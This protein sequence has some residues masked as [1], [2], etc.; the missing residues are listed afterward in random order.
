MLLPKRIAAAALLVALLAAHAAP[1]SAASVSGTWSVNASGVWS[2]AGNWT[3]ASA[4][5]GAGATAGLTYDI[6]LADRTVTIDTASR[7]VGIL[8]IGDTGSAYRSYTLAAS[9]GASLILDNSAAAAQINKVLSDQYATEASDTISAPILL[10]GSLNISNA[11]HAATA[12]LTISGGIT[13]NSAG[14]KTI[15]NR[16]TS[17]SGVTLSGVIGD[18][19]GTVAVTQNSATSALTLSGANTYSGATTVSA[20]TLK[21]GA[22]G[23]LAAGSSVSIAAGATFDVSGLG[24]SA[25]Y[26]LGISASLSAGGTAS[27]A[28]LKGGTSGTVDLGARP[29]ILAY[30]GSHA[31]L[32]I[33]QGTLK[34]NGNAFTVNGAALTNGSYTIV[35]QT[36]GNINSA[37]SYSVSGTAI[38]SDKTGSISVSSGMVLLAIE[39]AVTTTTTLAT[40]ASPSVYGNSVTLTATVSPTPPAGTIQFYDNGS[41]LG[42]PVTVNPVD[43]QAQFTSSTFTAGSHPITA[44]YSGTTGYKASTT[45]SPTT[46]PVNRAD[47]DVTAWP[48]AGIITYG[49][50]LADATLTGGSA[51]PAG[52]F[53]FTAPGTV[54]GA[55]AASYSVTF[56]PLDATNYNVATGSAEVTVNQRAITVTA[57]ALSK[58]YGEADP[59]LTSRITSGSLVI[60]DSLSGSL[61]RE[62]GENTGI[63]AIQQGKLTAGANYSLTFATANL[64]IAPKPLL[65]Q[66]DNQSRA[67]GAVNPPLTITYTGFVAGEGVTNLAALPEASTTADTNSLIGTYD[68]TL[69]GGSDTNYSLVLSNGTL[70]VTAAAITVT[71][72]AKGKIYGD[73]DPELTSQITSGA[74]REGDSLSG[75]LTRVAGE[76]AVAYAIQQG[77]LTAGTNYA[78]TFV[79]ADLTI[80]PKAI[81]YTADARGKV[82]G[83]VDPALTG[84]ITSGA[85]LEGDSLIGKLTRVAGENAGAY[86]IEQGTL[87]AG[88]NYALTFVAADLAIA[89]KPLLAQADDQSR[90][91]SAV[92]PP[93]TITYT[94][95]VGADSATN[96]AVLPEASTTADT[97]SLIGTYE[98]TLKGGSDTNYSLVLSNGTLTVT[99]AAITVTADAK[100]KV[101]GEADP[102][103]TSQI[104][105]GALREGD[106]LSG[107]L[108]RVAGE[109]AGAYAIQQGTLT[110]GTNYTLTFVTA[111]LTIAPKPLLAKAD[112]QSRAYGAVNMPLT[113]TYTGFVG[114]ESVTNLAV[115]PEASTAAD[116][117]SPVGAYDIAV[118]GGS[119]T[120]YSLVLSNG[121]LTVTAAA[122][123]VTADAKG[124]VYGDAD[125]ELTSQITSG[126]LREGD[127][128]SGSLTRVAGEEVGAYA[129]LQGKLTAGAN[130]AL[131]F[132]SADLTI[133]P[134]AITVTAD[135]KGKV[136]GDADPELTS[137]ITSGTLREGDSLSGSL[138]RVA[139]EDVGAYAIEQGTLTAGTNYTL[140]FVSADLTI[141]AAQS[142]TALVS[143]PNPST[144]GGS[145][146]FTATVTPVAPAASTPTGS[147]QFLTNGIALGGPVALISGVGTLNT[148]GLPAGTNTVT[149]AYLGDA[150]YNGSTNR[151]EQVV[152]NNV[153]TPSTLGIRDNGDG[154]VTI[155]FAGTPGAEY[156]VQAAS[157]LAESSWQSVSTNKAA[158]DGQW[159]FTDSTA[160]QPSR[161]YRS[162]KP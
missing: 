62:A 50:T 119:D 80:S 92:N 129:I 105:S 33:S 9:G 63:Y 10:N 118:A 109:N 34:L 161:F 60:G 2:A 54:P 94:G 123:T 155:T 36:S 73:A 31:A 30:D 61:T 48:T 144:H 87:T 139:G 69:T 71:A 17:S 79:S 64:T 32:T 47:P 154:T 21:L 93:L 78:L 40:S 114:S 28:T 27:A 77:T 148:A 124:K 110:A 152:T 130:Y 37:G 72:D 89:P 127:S 16:G 98:I 125:P 39:S 35:S 13:A 138:T 106:S 121:T 18:G 90:A 113:I 25:T 122:I 86:P 75:S 44:G 46:Q 49:Q 108:T 38:G 68:I 97:N 83:E 156:L 3:S 107:S 131:T 143:S 112:N 58:V 26:A 70:T 41:P 100:G 88:A 137:Q 147:V 99:A 4:P 102:E 134:K 52:N 140:A 84:Q 142:A 53:A 132:V 95:F 45:A 5:G 91:Y 51:T 56:T 149:A 6:S 59:V 82:Y 128:L 111:D 22:G 117:N 115:L 11:A 146:T 162:A 76:N 57:D 96:L 67:Y 12:I 153:E 29:I 19:S 135:A 55:G 42:S 8:N 126:A 103:L 159:T 101:Y 158:A 7:T 43:G 150:N 14:A 145:V 157:G 24:A 66:A 74:L 1:V 133:S 160:S 136:Y 15:S 141:A 120:N 81:T 104:T 65:A 85:L 20:G 23:S 116:T 151:L